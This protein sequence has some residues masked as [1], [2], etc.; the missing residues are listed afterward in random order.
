MNEVV[1]P[2]KKKSLSGAGAVILH[3]RDAKVHGSKL[4]YENAPQKDTLGFW[5][6][7][8]DWAEWILDVP[9]AGV[10]DVEVLQACGKGSGGSEIEVAVAGQKLTMKVAETGH[11]QRFI[12][13]TI[14]TLTFTAPGRHTL[15]VR[16]KTKPGGAVMD[17]RRI[18][19]RAAN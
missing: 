16:A 7:K 13:R 18:V 5:V 4:R 1:S 10:F 2:K 14:G 19:V 12:P 6:Q 15:T 17:L 9:N 11:F 8:D 3:A